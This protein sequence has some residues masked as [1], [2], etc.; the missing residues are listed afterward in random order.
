MYIYAMQA[1]NMLPRKRKLILQ[2]NCDSNAEG[3]KRSRISCSWGWACCSNRY[4]IFCKKKQ[5]HIHS[6]VKIIKNKYLNYSKSLSAGLYI[7]RLRTTNIKKTN[8]F[9]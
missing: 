4:T 6:D 3:G 1:Q 5:A 9:K 2:Q 8:A 7:L